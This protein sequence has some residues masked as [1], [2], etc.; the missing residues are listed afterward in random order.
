V[1]VV[2]VAVVSRGRALRDLTSASPSLRRFAADHQA[3]RAK[4]QRAAAKRHESQ[5]WEIDPD[6]HN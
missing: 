1:V 3:E 4:R 5:A 6:I 2:G